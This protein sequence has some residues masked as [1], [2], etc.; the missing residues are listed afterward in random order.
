[1][2]HPGP[3]SLPS[4]LPRVK[5]DSTNLFYTIFFYGE[6]R[7][8]LPGWQSREPD[9]GRGDAPG[10]IIP[11]PIQDG[12]RA[13][14]KESSGHGAHGNP[15]G[16]EATIR[17]GHGL[18]RGAPD[19]SRNCYRKAP[20]PARIFTYKIFRESRF[21][22][23]APGRDLPRNKSGMENNFE[24]RS[25]WCIASRGDGV[26]VPGFRFADPGRGGGGGEGGTGHSRG[27]AK[28]AGKCKRIRGQISGFPGRRARMASRTKE[29]LG[30][31]P[32]NLGITCG[33]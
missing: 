31:F 32:L 1:M 16:P 18:G 29:Q 20:P 14:G 4:K 22:G 25:G 27:T 33:E 12:S 10:D 8:L 15:E 19:K 17:V 2:R 30:P 11:A 28:T 7:R 23:G 13:P 21:R 24:M 26:P 3:P 9:I 5:Y 6:V